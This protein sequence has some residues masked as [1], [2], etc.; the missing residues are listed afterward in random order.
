MPWRTRWRI[1]RLVA[2][3]VVL[4]GL[5]IFLSDR[6]VALLVSSP[7]RLTQLQTVK[8]WVFVGV[9][10]AFLASI[11]RYETRA[12]EARDQALRD[13]EETYRTLVEV[14]TDGVFLMDNATGQILA[15][16]PAAAQLYGYTPQ[17]LLGLR[18]TDLSAEPAATEQV[19]TRTPL[20]PDSIIRIPLRHHKKRDGT[21]FPVEIT[22]RFFTWRGRAVQLAAIRDITARQQA[23]AALARYRVLVERARDIVLFVRRDGRILEANQAAAQ[24][25][26]YALEEFG[27]LHIQDLRALE[28]QPL[29][30]AQLA[31]ADAE[32]ILFETVHRRKDGTTFPVEVS[33]RGTELGGD[34]VLLSIVRDITDRKRAEGALATRTRHLEA[35]RVVTEDLTRELD[36]T[37]LL[38]LLIARAADLVGAASGTVYLW[39]PERGLMVPAA[40]HGLGDWQAALRHPPGQ[41]IVGT[42]AETRQGLCVNDYRS[43]RYANPLTLERTRV[44]ASLGEPL[45]YRDELIGAVTLNHDGGRIFAEEDQALLRLFANQAAIAIANARLFRE[46]RDR[47]AQ[48]EAVRGVSADIAQELDLTQVLHIV[49]QRA[50]E[51]TRATAADIALWDPERQ[52]LLTEASFGHTALNPTSLRRLGEGAM[53]TVAENRQGM[54]INDYRSSPVAHP[55]TLAHTKITASLVEPLMYR[56]TLLGV[57]GVD[58][59]TPGETFTGGDQALLRLFAD[60]AAIAIANARLFQDQ[61]RAYAALE[62]AQEELIRAE[63]LRGL[64]QMAAGIAHDLNNMLATVLGQAELLRMYPHSPEI[65]EGLQVLQM[66]ANDGAQVVRRLQDFA[67]QRGGGPLGPCDLSCLVPEALEITRPRWREEPRRKGIVIE[68]D[69]DLVGLPLIQG[70]AAEIREVLTNLIFNAVDAMPSGGRLRFTGEAVDGSDAGRP[71]ELAGDSAS[72]GSQPPWVELAVSD[73]GIGMT[74]D[75]RRHAFDPFFTTKGLHGTGLGLSVA[76]GI[77]ERHGGQIDVTSAP[78]QGTTF[79]LRFRSATTDTMQSTRRPTPAPVACRRILVVDDDASVRRTLAALLRASGHEVVEAEGGAAAL[80]CLGTTSVDLVLT[81]LGMPDV[82]GWDVARAAKARHPDLPVVLLTGWGDQVG[83]EA[84]SVTSVDRVL[85]KPLPRGAVLAVVAELTT[86]RG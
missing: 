50:C 43:S 80:D 31:R 35:V 26:G 83:A 67:R 63:K 24:A 68:T 11:L 49:A 30:P 77:M 59:V 1:S 41:G 75:V 42:V 69:V 81:D 28:T 13:S 34:R 62:R 64:G 47:R 3:Y 22:G 12:R 66:A 15:A 76:Y 74:E 71:G 53:G 60:Q 61:Q 4:A 79:R 33:S 23:E 27:T 16:N 39:E 78:G 72:R 38:R 2:V 57:I 56:D 20:V 46:E 40:W 51:L 21:V 9:T 25:Y 70:N 36:L 19:A 6:V 29:A 52:L 45:L 48:L 7:V 17:E 82:T 8:G 44:T 58:H 73:T 37:R 54:I 32:G 10:A 55:D 85:T 18:N 84:S 65:E 5:W 14:E 86:H